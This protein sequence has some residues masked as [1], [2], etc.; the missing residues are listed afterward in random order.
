MKKIIVAVL[1]LGL[2]LSVSMTALAA[3]NNHLLSNE[4]IEFEREKDEIYALGERIADTVNVTIRSRKGQDGFEEYN[5]AEYVTPEELNFSDMYK[6]YTNADE[7]LLKNL[8]GGEALD[9]LANIEYV[10]VFPIPVGDGILSV[11]MQR[12]RPLNEERA[13]ATDKYGERLL[14]DEQIEEIIANEGRWIVISTATGFLDK[15]I[16]A[17]NSFNEFLKSD[18]GISPVDGN[19][20]FITIP[21]LQTIAAFVATENGNYMYP[22]EENAIHGSIRCGSIADAGK[23]LHEFVNQSE[24]LEAFNEW[25]REPELYQNEKEEDFIYGG[26]G[27]KGNSAGII[28]VQVGMETSSSWPVL[29]IVG[30]AA[31]GIFLVAAILAYILKKNPVLFNKNK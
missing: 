29:P 7:I 23:Q 31:S 13:Y 24:L 2:A 20:H 3:D 28:S 8:L 6:L 11:L 5:N 30:I 27:G 15:N 9:A 1:L 16:A 10:W 19:V 14:T 4:T 25:Y 26:I 18:P 21:T 22:L 17:I 12:G